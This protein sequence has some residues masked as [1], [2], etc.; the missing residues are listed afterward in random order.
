MCRKTVL[1]LLL[2]GLFLTISISAFGQEKDRTK[3]PDK[4]KWN[5]ADIYPSDD[6]WRQAKEQFAAGMKKVEQFKGTIGKSPRNLLACLDYTFNQSKELAR[7]AVYAGLI[8]DQDTRDASHLAMTQ[9]IRQVGSDYG[10]KASY[11]EPEILAMDKGRI[12]G[13]LKKE[14]KLGVYR[15]YLDDLFRRKAHT[16]S[17][18]EEKIIA[19]ASLMADAPGSINNVF[20]N[21]EFPYPQVT[22]SDGQTVKIDKSSFTVYRAVPN[23]EDRKKVFAAFFGSLNDYRGTFGAQLY[24][25]VK[26]DM[27]YARARNYKSSLQSALDGSNIPVEVYHSLVDNVNKNLATFHRYLAMRKRILGVDTLHYYDLYPQLLKNVDLKYTVDEAEQNIL[28]AVAPL[29]PDYATVIRKALDERWID[30]YPTDGKRAGAYSNGGAYDVHPYMLLNYNGLYN[31]MSTLIHELG[32][33][34]QSYLSN[35]KQ[36]YPTSDYPTFVAEV[37]S[38]F[39]EALLIDYMLKNIKDDNVRLSLLGNYLEGIK[40]TVF[41]QTQFAEFEL[42]MHEMVE[43]GKTITGDNL[44]ELYMDITRRYYGHDKGI[45]IVD[46]DIKSEWAMIPHFFLNF[47]VFQYATSFTASAA[48]SEEVLTGDKAAREK[49]LAF[50]SAGGS[51]YPINLLKK[52]GVDMT[53]SQPLDLTIKKMNRVMDEMD[54][55]LKKMGK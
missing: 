5:L 37:A 12:A 4:Y 7:L 42:R 39:N 38:T 14:P 31:D 16:G 22:L 28:A 17:A 23:R 52:A 35:K 2:L 49:Y 32:H 18:Q 20:S 1:R 41:R 30:M 51:D 6:A 9:E 24:A 13:Y 10:A 55:I 45:C 54:E 40:G 29:G 15:Q 27:F 21:A 3:I 19:D 33:T 11:I 48:L 34:M 8:S 53:T 44:N 46:D 26:K 47:Y 43:K 50:L 36:P 25:E